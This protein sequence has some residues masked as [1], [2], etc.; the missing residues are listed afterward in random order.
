LIGKY[1]D[2][3]FNLIG[4]ENLEQRSSDVEGERRL[5]TKIDYSCPISQNGKIELG[6]QGAFRKIKNNF[7]VE[8][9]TINDW[10]ELTSVSND[11][12]YNENIYGIYGTY[13]Y[14]KGG[15]GYQ[16]LMCKLF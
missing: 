12:K 8:E 11:F 14:T 6:Y 2:S 4:I 9:R 16:I 3:N 1:F 15:L 5:I 7:K 13:K 10:R